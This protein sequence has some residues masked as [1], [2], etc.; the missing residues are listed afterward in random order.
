MEVESRIAEVTLYARGA[1]VRR[2][3]TIVDVPAGARVRI[4]GLPTSVIDDSVRVEAEGGPVVTAVHVGDDATTGEGAASEDSSEVRTGRLAVAM[5]VVEIERLDAALAILGAAPIAPAEPGDQ[6]PPAWAA[7]VEARRALVALRAERELALRDQL[8][9]AH[10]EVDEARRRLAAALDR[11]LRAGS[12]GRPKL[13]ELRKHVELELEGSGPATIYLEYQVAAA[14]WSPSYVARLDGDRVAFELRAVVAQDSGEDW[15]G[16]AL[17]LSTAEP[18]RFAVLPELASQR[19]GRRQ[20]EAA[21]AGFRAPPAGA[22]ALYDDYARAFPDSGDGEPTQER[23]PTVHVDEDLRSE[24]GTLREQAWDE[25]TSRA[26]SSPMMPGAPAL[27]RPMPMMASMAPMAPMASMAPAPQAKSGGVMAGMARTVL[28]TAAYA[29][30]DMARSAGGGG[31]PRAEPMPPAPAPRLDY[32]NLRMA[33]PGSVQRGQLIPTPLDPVSA[34]L[35]LDAMSRLERIERLALPVGCHADWPHTYDYAFTTDGTVDIASDRAWHS[36]AVTARSSTAKLRH[37]AVPRAQSDAFRI[38]V[39]ANPLAGPLL[40]GP[41]D[42]YD[43]GNFLVTSAVDQTPPGA[44]VEIGLGV[45]AQVKLSRNT[46]FREETTGVLRGG[47]RLHHTIKIDIDNLSERAIDLEVRERLPVPREGDDDVEVVT[48]KIDPAW[49]R[50][51]PEP[52][53]PRDRRL[54]G[55]YRWRLAIPA[56]TQR[57]LRAAYEV[58]IA[59]KHELVGGNRRES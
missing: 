32:T 44:T 24:L 3:A 30:P 46:E 33:P 50:W 39:I 35:E 59:G 16:V 26:R 11:Q 13:H 25:E 5:A 47:L 34:T 7:I 58:K 17:Q 18:E 55:G 4:A 48:G 37:V 49:E 22:A 45:D 29:M 10:R 40:P 53:A 14:R 52:D 28:G 23:V 12:G 54:R 57:T 27:S 15:R 38:A 41:I 19:I 42:V 8:A 21:R 9:A 20:A 2:A 31:R 51:V 1:R 36:I 6:P 43:R 56:R